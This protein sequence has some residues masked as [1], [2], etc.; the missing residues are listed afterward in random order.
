VTRKRYALWCTAILI[1]ASIVELSAETIVFFE[2]E[3]FGA[4][5]KDESGVTLGVT[6]FFVELPAGEYQVTFDRDGH[7]VVTESLSLLEGDVLSVSPQLPARYAIIDLP[8]EGGGEQVL[9]DGPYDLSRGENDYGI[10]PLYPGETRLRV[11]R[12]ATPALIAVAIASTVWTALAPPQ[13]T[14]AAIVPTVILQTGALTSATFAYRESRRRKQF[15]NEWTPPAQPY[16][17]RSAT[18]LAA[19]ARS[20]TESGDLTRARELFGRLIDDFPDAPSVPEALYTLGRFDL[21]DRDYVTAKRS[22]ERVQTEYP[23]IE[24]YD[25]TLLQLARIAYEEGDANRAEAY[26]Q[27]I[28]GSDP[29]VGDE[30]I[31]ALRMMFTE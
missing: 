13:A 21:I 8:Q 6:P 5:V 16:R 27:L 4:E 18:A 11:F 1:V 19:E 2:G 25:R 29:T 20:V 3:P 28:T 10:E 23:V 31:D 14:D 22:F 12:T 30:A 26:L 15:L 7:R 24:Y 9:P 17:P